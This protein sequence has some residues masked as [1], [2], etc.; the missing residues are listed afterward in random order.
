MNNTNLYDQW[1]AMD[2]NRLA[3]KPIS[4]RLPVHVL[5]RINAIS[6]LFPSK[7]R[8]DIMTDLIKAGLE[9]FEKSLPPVYYA[10][11][12]VEVEKDL[13]VYPAVG[14]NAEYQYKANAQYSELE[15]E[16]GNN[17]PQKLFSI[18]SK[19]A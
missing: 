3:S 19:K 5:A 7:T 6:E 16:L 9:S 13:S 11:E 12:A 4:I 15:K 10:N 1:R 18:S 2:D 8:T 14:A 17:D